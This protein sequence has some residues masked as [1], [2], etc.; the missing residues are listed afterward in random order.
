MKPVLLSNAQAQLLNSCLSAPG[1]FNRET[2]PDLGAFASTELFCHIAASVGRV[3]GIYTFSPR[4]GGLFYTSFK[5]TIFI[6][7]CMCVSERRGVGCLSL[8]CLIFCSDFITHSTCI[9]F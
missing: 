9:K 7:S 3:D 8:A 5:A 4:A 6:D 2:A 1:Q